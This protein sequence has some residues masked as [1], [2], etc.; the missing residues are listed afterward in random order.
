MTRRLA[1]ALLLTL[2]L[3]AHA[4]EP[5]PTQRKDWKVRW[6]LFQ[7]QGGALEKIPNAWEEMQDRVRRA[8]K[9]GYNGIVFGDRDESWY[10]GDKAALWQQR[11][12]E[13][14]RLTRSLDMD[15]LKPM[16]SLTSDRVFERYTDQVR[17][18]RQVAD[19]DGYMMY[20]DEMRVGGWEPKSLQY[21]TCGD[22]INAALKRAYGIVMREGGGKPVHTW[23]DMLTPSHNAHGN[24][25]LLRN[26]AAGAGENLPN[27]LRIWVWGGGRNGAKHFGYFGKQNLHQIIC[28]YYDNLDIEKQYQRWMTEI[29]QAGVEVDGVVYSSWGTPDGRFEKLEEFARVWW[30]G[31]RSAER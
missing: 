19:P 9:A 16:P 15:L 31:G 14:R 12:G 2:A 13:L 5:R 8:A 6:A 3:S 30:G 22:L 7:Y 17:V 24:Y 29:D 18:L 10:E 23:H 11:L 4:D 1:I 26:T 25:Y 21:E 28:T 27:G 20:F